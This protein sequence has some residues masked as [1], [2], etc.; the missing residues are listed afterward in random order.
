MSGPSKPN[1]QPIHGR[2]DLVGWLESG[3]KPRAEWRLGTEHEKFAYRLSDKAPLPYADP[4]GGPGIRD[5]LKGLEAYGWQPVEENGAVIAMTRDD[6]GSISLEPGGQLELSGAPLETVHQTCT[7]VT[8]HRKQV[9]EVAER[10]GV[11]LIG[12]GFAPT[13]RREDMHWM[14]KGRYAI[15]REYMPKVGTM[16]LDMMLRTC[17]VQVN[18]DYASEA[19][20]VKKFRVATALQPLATALWANSPF[21]E[22]QLNGYRSYRAHVWTDTDNNRAGLPEFAFEDGFGF[23][24]Y[25]DYL[26]DVP[27]YFVARD[28]RYINVAGRSF[29]D[30]LEGKLPE[31]PGE[32]PTLGDWADHAST[33]FPDVRLKKY[34]EMRG[35]DGG[36]WSRLCALPA[37]W[38]GLLYDDD[39]LDE[40]WHLVKDWTPE[41]R[42]A[43]HSQVPV[44]ALKTPFRGGTVQDLALEAL[45]IARAGLGRRARLSADGMDESG[46]LE[47]LQRIADTGMTPADELIEA[48]S[49]RWN[50]SL[51]P[52]WAAYA[53]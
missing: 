21:K 41:E 29:R 25:V 34:M 45:R 39:A 47:P 2:D 16:G 38:G 14:P 4:A 46:F 3:N 9:R 36:P 24:R 40:A 53:Y 28:G 32:T 1:L 33:A 7:E 42:R 35:S 51:E 27:M 48:F 20:M 6:G 8:T 44:T 23:E 12:L 37:F 11:G 30:F 5:M 18:M 13:W 17:T 10:L 49:S 52:L 31:L 19:D 50:G 15:M 43:L 26:L 22:G